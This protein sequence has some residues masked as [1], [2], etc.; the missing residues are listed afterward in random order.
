M[1]SNSTNGHILVPSLAEQYRDALK[2]IYIDTVWI[3]PLASP[4]SPVFQLLA[5]V[6]TSPWG[7]R[8]T[9]VAE[10]RSSYFPITLLQE[11]RDSSL[12]PI[13]E[14]LS[15]NSPRR[16]LP[17]KNFGFPPAFVTLHS[18][19]LVQMGLWGTDG[20]YADGPGINLAGCY[21]SSLSCRCLCAPS[22]A[23]RPAFT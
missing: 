20:S 15:W 1:N 22:W 16:G 9:P 6:H 19:R 10:Y 4:G 3:P 14:F 13:S 2:R 7:F 18:S 23:C 17:S 12:P 21:L 5:P 11:G 8:P